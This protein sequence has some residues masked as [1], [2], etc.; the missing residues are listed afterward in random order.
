[1]TKSPSGQRPNRRE[2]A[3]K[4]STARLVAVQ[5]IYEMEVAGASTDAVLREILGKRWQSATD[6]DT[7]DR[8]T[9]PDSVFLGQVVR[10]ATERL[11]E[12]DRAIGGALSEKWTVE[13]LEVLLRCV[14][15]AGTYELLARSD[16]PARVVISE[17][18]DVAHA[19]F[20]GDEPGLVNGV[21]DRLARVLRPGEIANGGRSEKAKEA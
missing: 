10:G 5:A 15:R 7:A 14:L 1:M 4:R 9:E 19:F 3:R 17:Y 12:L 11:E 18:V 20:S 13:R 21:L 16:V 6:I 2:S 8:M